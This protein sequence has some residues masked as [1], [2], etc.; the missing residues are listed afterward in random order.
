MSFGILFIVLLALACALLVLPA[1]RRDRRDG[2]ITRDAL[3]AEFYQRRLDELV[4]DEAQ[5]VVDERLLHINELKQNLLADIPAVQAR[6]RR[7]VGLWVLAPGAAAL[8]VV[9][10]ALYAWTGGAQQ[11]WRWQRT[12]ADMPA[13]RAR[14][15][16]PAAKQLTP[17]ELAQFAV[18][19]RASLQ[20]QPQNLQDWLILGRIGVVLNNVAMATQAFERAYRLVPDDRTIALDYAEVLIRSTDPGDNQEG[21][22][23]LQALVQQQP[24]NVAALNL[25]AIGQYQQNNYAQAIALW[26]H[27]L[28]LLPAGDPHIDTI[29]RSIAQAR[30]QSGQE[31]AKLNVIV[32][33][34]AAAAGH[35]P[36]QGTVFISVTDGKSP[37]PV[38]VKPL[39]MSRFPLSLSLDD[40]NAMLP[41]RLLS[42][43]QQVKVRVRIAAD[44]T[45]QAKSGDWFGESALRD[46]N[47]TGRIAVRIDQQVP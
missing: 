28:P 40:G 10:L 41:E 17:G 20:R 30:E 19:L 13:L 5:G 33:L 24:D 8:V 45:A 22:R 37:V 27:I 46:F 32:T 11:V 36:A 1:L 14:I 43:Q 35:L 21:I 4:Q 23:L 31:T 34:S 7:P 39:P 15:M 42:A 12:V 2:G 38:A 44:G 29:R 25:L 47:G 16:D 9:T 6:E 18:G 3:N 26:Q